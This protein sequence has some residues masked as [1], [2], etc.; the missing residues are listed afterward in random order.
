MLFF[1]FFS[2][3]IPLSCASVV[4]VFV[5]L[6]ASVYARPC[7]SRVKR[8]TRDER[9]FYTI[10]SRNTDWRDGFLFRRNTNRQST[11][12]AC[13]W[14]K[15]SNRHTAPKVK[16]KDQKNRFD[17]HPKL[18]LKST[19]WNKEKIKKRKKRTETKRKTRQLENRF[20][21]SF[22]V[23]VFLCFNINI[24]LFFVQEN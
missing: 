11:S 22:F 3:L 10:E 14:R 17:T 16:K 8:L 7:V 4:Y 5:Y 1:F 21:R 19:E 12:C 6:C 23:V 20:R 15:N 9:I 2:F 24:S 13:K 18:K